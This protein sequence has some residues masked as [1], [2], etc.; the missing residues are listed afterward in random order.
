MYPP[1]MKITKTTLITQPLDAPSYT[2]WLRH[3]KYLLVVAKR[4][5]DGATINANIQVA[6]IF[7]ICT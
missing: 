1:P 5:K 3:Q 4:G 7:F 2:T 6:T